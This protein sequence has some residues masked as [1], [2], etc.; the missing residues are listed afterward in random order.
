MNIRKGQRGAFAKHV[1]L[2]LSVGYGMK[3][4][5]LIETYRSINPGTYPANASDKVSECLQKM[6]RKGKC[7][8]TYDEQGNVIAVRRV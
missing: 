4:D 3:K 8:C 6:E 1:E 7:K 2:I 5:E